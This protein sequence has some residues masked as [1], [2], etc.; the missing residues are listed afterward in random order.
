[1]CVYICHLFQNSKLMSLWIFYH[2]MNVFEVLQPDHHTN[3]D[4]LQGEGT[5]VEGT[6]Q[7][8]RR[9]RQFKDIGHSLHWNRV[10]KA[11]IKTSD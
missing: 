9:K 8:Y 2:C 1:M 4:P 7:G 3:Q 6:G 11:T 10:H 5:L